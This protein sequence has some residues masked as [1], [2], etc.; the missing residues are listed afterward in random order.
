M[1]E[2]EEIK[3]REVKKKIKAQRVGEDSTNT[4]NTRDQ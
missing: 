4:V 1:K 2:T 3:A